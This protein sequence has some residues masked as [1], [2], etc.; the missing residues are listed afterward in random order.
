MIGVAKAQHHYHCAMY[1]CG[2]INA[3]RVART[4]TV[5]VNAIPAAI[6]AWPRGSPARSQRMPFKPAST[7]KWQLYSTTISPVLPLEP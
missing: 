5:V 6:L 1:V 3:N 4:N 7:V 2:A